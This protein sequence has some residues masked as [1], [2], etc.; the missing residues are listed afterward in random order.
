MSYSLAARPRA[1][2]RPLS[3]VAA[4]LLAV[5]AAASIGNA[6]VDS[7]TPTSYVRRAGHAAWG[8]ATS[9]VVSLSLAVIVAGVVLVVLG[10]YAG[11]H[12]PRRR[13]VLIA[14]G[15]RR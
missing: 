5:L 8:I 9:L 1:V 7:L 10:W 13:G 14:G 3:R 11:G 2:L 12:A 4:V 6:L 15:A